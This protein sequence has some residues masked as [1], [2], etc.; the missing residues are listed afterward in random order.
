MASPASEEH[1]PLGLHGD[2]ARL[3]TV[4]K[5]EKF[6]G[7]S[8]N[9]PLFRPSAARYSRFMVFVIDNSK[10]YKNRTMNEVWKRLAWS[11][12][13]CFEGINPTI[14][15]NSQPLTG[16]DLARAGMPLTAQG[17]KFTITEFRGDWEWHR[18]TWRPS[19][20]WISKAICFKCSSRAE[21]DPSLLYTNV[22]G[23]AADACQWIREEFSLT[24]FI[25]RRLKENNLCDS[26]YI[27]HVPARAKAPFS[28]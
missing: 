11:F 18:D 26:D 19:A 16:S 2:G 6:V 4:S 27:I 22:G 13:S 3:W 14:G 5:Y 24:S 17:Y 21:G 23:S 8:M 12:N 10:I 28:P 1:I 25:S 9:L 20:S 15:W 7:I